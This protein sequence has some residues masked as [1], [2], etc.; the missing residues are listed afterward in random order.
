[1][2]SD[3]PTGG[4][5]RPIKSIS[6]GEGET[7]LLSGFGPFT[8]LELCVTAVFYLVKHFSHTTHIRS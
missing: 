2:N 7:T 5:N 6:T 8:L 1:M 4:T 3:Q